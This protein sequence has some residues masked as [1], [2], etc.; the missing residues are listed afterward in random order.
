MYR[1][2]TP[3][4]FLSVCDEVGKIMVQELSPLI[5]TAYGGGEVC[6][7]GVNTPTK[8]TDRVGGGTG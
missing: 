2:V 6:I 5:G 1:M 4:Q 7:G 8:R 3:F